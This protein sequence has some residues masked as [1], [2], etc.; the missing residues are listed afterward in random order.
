MIKLIFTCEHSSNRIPDEFLY[1][2]NENKE[3]LET[4][5][6][7]DFGAKSIFDKFVSSYDSLGFYGLFSRLIIDLNRQLKSKTL[8]SEFTYPLHPEIKKEIIEKY[9]N[10]YRKNAFEK[11]I[12]LDNS[13]NKLIHISIHSFT[14]IFN[15]I[16]RKADIGLLYYPKSDFER[17]LTHNWK[18]EINKLNKSIK[19]MF[20]N[21]YHGYEDGLTTT[22]RNTLGMDNYAGIELEINQ[23]LLFDN[24]EREILINELSD[25]FLNL[26]TTI[27]Y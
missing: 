8:F 12:S 15:N 25:S 19:V 22:M 7:Y 26:L 4:H 3:I 1:L 9:Y 17:E 5:R 27:P 2:F 11:I 23:R 10:P 24:D 21:P 13:K 16:V 20:N 14:P 18:K 6:A